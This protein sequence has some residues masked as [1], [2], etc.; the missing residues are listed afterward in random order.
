MSQ[1][2]PYV[3]GIIQ[4]VRK[5]CSVPAADELLTNSKAE[6]SNKDATTVGGPSDSRGSH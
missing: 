2:S 4:V 5:S 1:L 3:R 6:N